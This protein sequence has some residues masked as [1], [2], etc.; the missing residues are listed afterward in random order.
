MESKY[1]AVLL[2]ILGA[3]SV[4]YTQYDAKPELTSFE[5][6]MNQYN[7]KYD[8]MFERAYREKIFLENLA[9]IEAHNS[10]K[11]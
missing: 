10:G 2:A 9:K 11:Q 4:L 8:S 3:V 6:W 7:V 5:N 1:L